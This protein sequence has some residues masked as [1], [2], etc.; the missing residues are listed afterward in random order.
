MDAFY[1]SI[2][3]RDDPKLR[4]KPVIVGGRPNERGVVAAASY[5]ARKYGIHSAMATSRAIKLCPHVVLVRGRMSHY[6]DISR[7]IRSILYS[8]TSLVEPLS[9]DEAFLDVTECINQYGSASKI[10]REL[11]ER[12]RTETQLTCSVGVAPN[13]FIA[14]IASDLKKPDGFVVVRPEKAEDFLK[15][16]PV[17]RIWGVGKA[18]ESRLHELQINTIGDVRRFELHDLVREFGKWGA[19]LHELSHGIDE[20]P[21]TANRETKSISRETTFVRDVVEMSKLQDVIIE[22][23]KEVRDDLQSEKLK[24]KT[25]Q[26]KVRYA[27]FTTITRSFTFK[28]PIDQLE[29]LQETAKLLLKHKVV[30]DAQGIRLIGVG[31]SNLTAETPQMP[32][33]EELSADSQQDLSRLLQ[34]LRNSFH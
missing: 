10:G 1:A 14:K 7:Q 33:L 6:R 23:A 4:G 13:K 18:T 3:Q 15:D 8:Y 2:E 11:K 32:L 19:R 25:L 21:V 28:E 12:V 26:I 30:P 31:V 16:L 22:L 27:D 34:D 9:L 5:E 29:I 20:R 17:S 24:A